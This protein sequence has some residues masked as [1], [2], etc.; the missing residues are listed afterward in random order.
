MTTN[1]ET[2]HGTNE[3]YSKI[4]VDLSLVATILYDFLFLRNFQLKT[5]QVCEES[6]SISLNRVTDV[7]VKCNFFV[8]ELRKVVFQ[9]FC[10]HLEG[11]FLIF[12]F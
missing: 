3:H 10:T 5:S 9:L 12:E 2:G 11:E 1:S 4:W 8:N 6:V 7:K